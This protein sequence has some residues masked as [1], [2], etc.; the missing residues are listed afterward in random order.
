MCVYCAL[1]TA[2]CHEACNIAWSK[3]ISSHGLA[4]LIGLCLA[5]ACTSVKVCSCQLDINKMCMQS[6]IIAYRKLLYN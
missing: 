4:V 5:H 2:S 6:I 1:I 3:V